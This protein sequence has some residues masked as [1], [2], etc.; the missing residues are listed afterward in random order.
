MLIKFKALLYE[1]NQCDSFSWYLKCDV[2]NLSFSFN[3][4][5]L[6]VSFILSIVQSKLVYFSI[7]LG[8]LN[9]HVLMFGT[10]FKKNKN[11][12][13]KEMC[14]CVETNYYTRVLLVHCT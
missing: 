3:L 7:L 4:R 6:S 11:L 9:S 8:I 12:K 13:L 10:N 1:Y 5:N 14:L 2:S